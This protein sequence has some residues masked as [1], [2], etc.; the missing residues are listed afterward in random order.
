M[1]RSGNLAAIIEKAVAEVLDSNLPRLRSEIVQRASS[2]LE[3]IGQGGVS[4]VGEQISTALAGIHDAASQAEILKKLLEGAA[5]FAPR[6]ALFVVRGGSVTGWQAS[7]FEDNEVISGASLPMSSPLVARSIQDRRA[8]EGPTAQFDASLMRKLKPP[9]AGRC[10]VLPLVVKDKVAALLY[11]DSGSSS[12][13][14][15][16]SAP[17]SSL[18][19]FAGVWLELS[20]LRKSERIPGEESQPAAAPASAMASPT[21][22]APVS[23]PEKSTETDSEVGK[24]ARRFAKL[25]VEEIKLYNE[26]KVTEGRENRDLYERLKEDIEK[27]RA[28]Y[29]KRYGQSLAASGEYFNQELVR[30][31]ADND[32]TLM[33]NNFPQ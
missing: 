8:A 30:I 14:N 24:K 20:A 16:Q 25:L 2:E 1:P 33:G 5:Q 9:A 6:V 7:G 19:R 22:P 31:L 3:N 26:N 23:A 4:A 29:E 21:V 15:Y 27:S 28:T 13:N 12:D 18:M 17:L 32:I 10:V 11:V